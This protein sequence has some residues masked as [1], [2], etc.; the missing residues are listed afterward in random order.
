MARAGSGWSYYGFEAKRPRTQRWRVAIQHQ[1]GSNTVIDVAYVGS[2]ADRLYIAGYAEDALPEQYWASGEVRNDATA[3]YLNANL[4]NPFQLSNFESLRTSS[5]VVY[6]QMSTLAF[7]TSPTIRRSQLLRPFP[8]MNVLSRSNIPEGVGRTHS[9]EISLERR[10]SQGFSGNVAYTALDGQE[11]I[12]TLNEFELPTTYMPTQNGRPHRFTVAGIVELP[13]GKGRRY[14][15]SG[16]L[17][18]VFGG[19]QI[20]STYEWQAGQLVEF[21]NPFYYGDLEDIKNSN[22][23]L[24]RW[25]NTDGF[26]RTANRTPAAF[27]RRVF[28]LR[29]DG[30]RA[31]STNLASANLSR[32]FPFNESMSLE[33]RADVLNLTN[34]SQFSP[35]NSTPTSTNFGRI[36]SAIGESINRMIQLQARFRF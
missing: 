16:V 2:W 10:F 6:Q 35:P 11:R 34:R 21:L 23:T 29:V 24:D 5:P 1:L 7:F 18:H 12:Q 20:A 31:Q 25:F 17:N 9:M 15:T 19:W 36:T 27:H 22:P 28:P 4:P 8:H 30:V 3:N 33:I 26:E 14:L 32:K 13:F